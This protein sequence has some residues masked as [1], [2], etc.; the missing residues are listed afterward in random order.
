MLMCQ[1][2]ITSRTNW[3]RAWRLR[4]FRKEDLGAFLEI[5][6]LLELKAMDLAWPYLVDENLRAARKAMS[7]HIRCNH[8]RMSNLCQEIGSQ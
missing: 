8:S 1:S 5:R 4:P 3:R 7:V 2:Q 6:E